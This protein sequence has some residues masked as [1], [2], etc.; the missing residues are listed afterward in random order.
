MDTP[1]QI[2]LLSLLSSVGL[3]VSMTSILPSPVEAAIVRANSGLSHEKLYEVYR[4]DQPIRWSDAQDYAN[5]NL[6]AK[7]VS[8]GDDSENAYI[9]T[10]IA[11][12]SLWIDSNSPPGYRIGPYI[13]LR[14]LPG[15][16]EPKGGW[17][18]ENLT[19]VK[20]Y[21]NWFRNQPDNY[22]G[23]DVG[24]FYNGN[25]PA[26]A[27]IPWGDVLDSWTLTTG[28]YS[29]GPNP[30]LAQSFVI[31]YPFPL[32]SIVKV[33]SGIS[34]GFLYEVYR[35]DALLPFSHA[36]T[37]ARIILGTKLAV[38]KDA[39]QNAFISSLITDPSL[40]VDSNSPA[41][42][43]I[44]PYI[45]L[46][47][48]PGSAEHEAGWFWVDGTPLSGYT[49]WFFNQPDNYNDDNVGL[50]YNG[51]DKALPDSQWGDVVNGWN[52][53]VGPYSPGR[54]PFLANS[55]V[56]QY[57]RPVPGPLPLMAALAAF[58]CTRQ[59]RRRCQ[60]RAPAAPKHRFGPA[61]DSL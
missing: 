36:E 61:R 22:S 50:F 4:S 24:V 29:P 26:S 34:G 1:A 45:G 58:R 5:T 37:Y 48:L 19:P 35:S 12:P 13:G 39:A 46:Y 55:F 21:S 32:A 18:W 51:Y 43:Y 33:A 57:P 7:L 11:D 23:D 25:E 52:I 28:P 31:E 30:F 41:Y 15:S 10:L 14:Q 42:N 53:S 38:I 59:L 8:I 20:A 60:H 27:S 44:G 47:Q 56:V 17:R 2:R 9:S 16:S 3:A 49:N 40:W 6:L 54:N